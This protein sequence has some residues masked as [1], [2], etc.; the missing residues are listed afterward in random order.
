M[1]LHA[2]IVPAF[3]HTAIGT[4]IL[5]WHYQEWE[6]E[7]V[8][9]RFGGCAFMMLD[10]AILLLLSLHKKSSAMLI[11]LV[12][13]TSLES[14]SFGSDDDADEEIAGASVELAF[15]VPSIQLEGHSL[16]SNRF[17]ASYERT[18]IVFIAHKTG[19]VGTDDGCHSVDAG[20]KTQ[21]K[22]ARGQGRGQ[23]PSRSVWK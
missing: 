7:R 15:K 14:R 3:I 4:L 16:S 18:A 21:L 23:G 19:L 8:N 12:A 22:Q 17:S 5:G 10:L 13:A 2:C 11:V 6:N 9:S 20:L 1:H